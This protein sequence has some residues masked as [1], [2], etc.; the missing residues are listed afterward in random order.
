[1]QH[2]KRRDS[3]APNDKAGYRIC[4]M[5]SF[6]ISSGSACSI[7]MTVYMCEDYKE[8][9][10]WLCACIQYRHRDIA[11]KWLSSIF[12]AYQTSN[13]IM[14]DHM[15]PIVFLD[16]QGILL[17]P[18]STWFPD[19]LPIESIWPWVSERQARNSSSANTFDEVWS[20]L[21]AP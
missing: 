20:R 2:K 10:R 16:T 8:T 9:A 3:G 5:S 6:Q 18:W 7:L 14:Q 21:E 15:L 19:L 12:K 17:L 1:M 13:E 4:T 11:P